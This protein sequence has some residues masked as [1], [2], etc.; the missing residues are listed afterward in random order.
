MSSG[1]AA[2]A[3]IDT[4]RLRLR[5]P[6]EADLAALAG[7]AGERRIATMLSAM[8]HP[9]GEAEARAFLA[10]SADPANGLHLAVER[11]ADRAFLGCAG[12][13][14]R[15]GDLELGYWIGLPHQG[16]GFATEAAQALVDHAF[17]AVRAG[18]LT[19]WTRMRNDASRRVLHKCGFQFAGQ[20]MRDTLLAGRVAVE[21]YVLERRVWAGLRNWAGK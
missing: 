20:G 3:L 19:A 2:P 9:Y 10:F 13:N 5:P 11:K 15:D 8:P 4:L 18:R 17:A 7:L 6:D 1:I 14:H 21:C 12:L 16:S